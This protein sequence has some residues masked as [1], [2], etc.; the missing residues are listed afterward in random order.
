MAPPRAL[1]ILSKKVGPQVFFLLSFGY[2]WYVY[3]MGLRLSI[4][5]K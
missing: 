2:L 1:E 5:Q 3:S 4:D